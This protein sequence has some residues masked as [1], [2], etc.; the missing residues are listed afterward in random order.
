VVQPKY[1][2]DDP[3]LGHPGIYGGDCFLVR[4]SPD[5]Q[6]I[7]TATYFGGSKQERNV[8][9]MA[10]DKQ[11][12]ILITTNTR[13]PD[14][15]TTEGCF[16]PKYGGGESDWGVAKLSPDCQRVL[17]CTYVGGSD[18]DSPRGGL[19]V[20][21]QDN[22]YVVGTTA[23]PNFPTT[24]G[25]LQPNRKGPR[26]S[27]IVKLKPD[28]SG[29]VYGTLV[30]GTGEDDAMMG[31]RV[32]GAGNAYIAGHT[33][34]AD[35]PVTPGAAQAQFGGQSDCYLAKLSSDAS[36]LLYATYLGGAQNEFAEHCP[37]L[38]AE[39]V[40]LLTGVMSSPDFPTTAN[41]FQRN[42]K[43]PNDG[44]LTRLSPDGKRFLLS[45]FLGG[46]GGEFFLMPTLDTAGNLFLVG[47]TNSQDFPVTPDALQPRFGGGPNDGALVLLSPDGSQVRYATYLG[48]S[49]DD[50]IRS[51]ALGPQGELYLV[52][53]TSSPDFPT[54]P[55]AAQTKLAGNGDAFVVK[56]VSEDQS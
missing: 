25:V 35:F 56:L 30:G 6:K 11:G 44:F 12:N 42:L 5:G 7:L 16:Q 23:S 40:F 39:G 53:S 1:A 46:S 55:N 19:T 18:G 50:M 38:T 20:D 13:S 24:P 52:G 49:G 45:T 22:V 10:L 33:Q 8:Y 15:P 32:D 29:L 14:L 43:G 3:A 47:Q 36:R 31:V 4:L 34:S 48:G 51:L 28:G 17:W 37:W 26:D 41:A 21:G 2:G 9:G 54:T 27:A